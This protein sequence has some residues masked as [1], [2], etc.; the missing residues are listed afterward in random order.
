MFQ[1]SIGLL[2][3]YRNFATRNRLNNYQ[4]K[5]YFR[6][7]F[8]GKFFD[9]Q[10]NQ[11]SMMMKKQTISSTV[12]TSSSSLDYRE[13]KDT[14]GIVRV[15]VNRLYGA[16][17]QRSLNNFHI[18][19]MDWNP[20][21]MPKELIRAFIL[22]KKACAHVNQLNGDLDERRAQAIQ[23]ACDIILDEQKIDMK[24]EFP[25]IIWQTGSGTHTNMNCNEVLANLAMKIL[26]DNNADEKTVKIH[27]ND[28][29]NRSQSSNDTFPTAMHIAIAL[30][31]NG[32]LLPALEQLYKSLLT[33]QMEFVNIIKIGRTHLQDATPITLGQEFSA[34]SQQIKFSIDRIKSVLEPR[35]YYL[36]IGGTAVGTGLNSPEGWDN[37]VCEEISRITGLNFRP[38]PNKFEAL[39][40]NDVMVE[41]SGVLNVLACS[42]N[43]IAND[44]RWLASGPRSGLGELSLPELE[45]GSSIMP[46][47][48]NPTQ[49]ES[50]TMICAQIQGN[51]LAVTIGGMQGHF[52]LNVFK[53]M[54]IANILRS[55]RLLTDSM[56]SF[57]L[58]CIDHIRPNEKR[59]KQ[60]MQNSLM[61]ATALNP[62]IGY[63]QAALLA[64]TAYKEDA[65]LKDTAIKLGMMTGE[66]F[67]EWIKPDEM[68]R[69]TKKNETRKKFLK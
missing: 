12:S 49:S 51:H 39:S 5:Q 46:G 40:S 34:Y 55:S 23:Q 42:L 4:M 21:Q 52:Q 62:Y 8:G 30:E 63:D 45:P 61:L 31:L 32:K 33:K 20:E 41:L 48:I 25:L 6:E 43:K 56:Q 65:R 28:H 19:T 59:I 67:D 7:L 60:L 16:Q 11:T 66:Q 27:P 22:L 26:N 3:F 38:A 18:G 24:H 69:P 15:P 10:N 35:I 9:K 2:L 54:I 44:I 17:T 14:L 29:C 57:R 1:R 13:E 50:M 64:R 53:P 47:K 58:N 37:A 36:A 68:I